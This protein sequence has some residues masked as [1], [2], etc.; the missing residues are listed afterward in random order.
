MKTLYIFIII[1]FFT[2]QLPAQ[3]IANISSFYDNAFLWNPALTG[4][5]NSIEITASHEQEWV[6]FDDAPK[7]STISLQYPFYKYARETQSSI[8]VAVDF[9]AIGPLQKIG[10]NGSYSYRFK[11]QMFGNKNDHFSLGFG[12]Q[13]GRYQ[14]DPTGL[15]AYDGLA[16]DPTV[17]DQVQRSVS[18]NL[19]LGMYYISNTQYFNSKDLYYF[20]LSVNQAI[21]NRIS[22]LPLM[23]ARMHSTLQAGYRF[24]IDKRTVSHIEPNVMAIYAFKKAFHALFNVRYNLDDKWW[25]SGGIATNGEYF[26]QTGV[27]LDEDSFIGGML[28]NSQ[29]L[30]GVKVDYTFG[31]FNAYR[32]VGYEGMVSFRKKL[33]R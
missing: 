31:V 18:P 33:E 13:L 19:N 5:N 11:P 21:P 22:S 10:F 3:Q 2:I 15:N 28:N 16:N 25:L 12:V 23:S 32:G 24:Y 26:G 8:G 1:I 20:G 29:L 6:G 7:Y 14:Y 4:K 30:I 27:I 9:D 17:S